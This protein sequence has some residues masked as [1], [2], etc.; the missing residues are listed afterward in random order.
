MGL[1]DKVPE[2]VLLT[3]V[4]AVAGWMR[5]QGGTTSLRALV[6]MDEIFGYLPPIANPPSAMRRS[7]AA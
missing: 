6:Y 2:G 3:T 4:E 1:E 5:T 7:K